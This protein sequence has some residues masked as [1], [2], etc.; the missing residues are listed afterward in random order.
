MNIKVLKFLIR[1]E[2]QQAKRDRA[3]IRMAIVIPCILLLILPWAATF[4]QKEIRLSIIDNDHS[5]YSQL[6][7]DK[8]TSS[9][10]F[11][12][13]DYSSSYTKGLKQI[14]KDQSDMLIEI[15]HNFERDFKQNKDV[16]LM[17]SINS[18]NGQKAGLGSNYINQIIQNFNKEYKKDNL[19]N[20]ITIAPFFKYND[21]MDYKI[22]ILPGILAMLLTIVGGTLSALNVVREKENGTIESLNV[23][24]VSRT[25]LILSKLIPFWLIGIFV[26]TIGLLITWAVY[27]LFPLGNILI[28]YLSAFVYLLTFTALGLVIANYSETQQ[29][30]ML[31]AFMLFLACFMLSGIFTPISSMPNWAQTVTM[32]NPIRHFVEIIRLVFMKGSNLIEIHMRFIYICIFAIIFNIWAVLSYKKA[33]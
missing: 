8:V 4:E 14:E 10:L 3:I 19:T 12:I 31:V 5:S 1:K 15:P 27:G 20:Q 22:F 33:K 21:N 18:I 23:T 11:I 16:E 2:L 26:L 28:I 30:A 9:D 17:V 13:N 29:Q 7:L 32:F 25:T 24:P 6:L